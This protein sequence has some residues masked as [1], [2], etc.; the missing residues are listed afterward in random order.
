[1]FFVFDKNRA[2]RQDKTTSPT[3]Q[4]TAR[5]RGEEEERTEEQEDM[6]ILSKKSKSI[7]KVQLLQ[8]SINFYYYNTTRYF[9][10]V[11]ATN[12]SVSNV[13]ISSSSSSSRF[14]C[15]VHSGLSGGLMPYIRGHAWQTGLLHQMLSSPYYCSSSCDRL[16]MFQHDP[17]YTLGRGANEQHLLFFTKSK[18]DSCSHN[19]EKEEEMHQYLSSVLSRSNK[20]SPAH[21]S[22]SNNHTI[23]IKST[24]AAMSSDIN[25]NNGKLL[26]EEKHAGKEE[27]KT[28]PIPTAPNGAAIYRVERGGQVTFHGPGAS[29]H[30]KLLKPNKLTPGT[31]STGGL[32]L[33]LPYPTPPHIVHVRYTCRVSLA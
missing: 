33:F 20:A 30:V 25:N 5:A 29:L 17:V 2:E 26:Y 32:H 31:S 8:R 6:R 21:L 9:S 10:E 18:P 11:V 28:T 1:V 13:V 14:C 15:Y 19:P 12:S 23:H 27:D 16:L 24:F 22:F 3:R 7:F 4:P